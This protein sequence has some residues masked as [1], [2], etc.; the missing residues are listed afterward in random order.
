MWLSKVG[1]KEWECNSRH[2][3]I[4]HLRP[5][6]SPCECYHQDYFMK[7]LHCENFFDICIH[8]ATSEWK[9]TG[10]IFVSDVVEHLTI[11]SHCEID[12]AH[13]SEKRCSQVFYPGWV[14]ESAVS[15]ISKSVTLCATR[16]IVHAYQPSQRYLKGGRL[17]TVGMAL[18]AFSDM[19]DFTQYNNSHLRTTANAEAPTESYIHLRQLSNGIFAQ[20]YKKNEHEKYYHA[21]DIIRLCSTSESAAV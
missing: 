11:K 12:I 13:I 5:A 17:L 15:T 14:E 2:S 6:D 1:G 4:V 19:E 10:A 18:R 9:S 8:T 3:H 21:V 20:R 16:S 7:K